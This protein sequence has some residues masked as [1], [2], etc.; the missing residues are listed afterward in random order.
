MALYVY[1]AE[2]ISDALATLA[3]NL[4]GP[5]GGEAV[6]VDGRCNRC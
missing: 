6:G 3:K 4:Q 5:G 1:Q 2:F